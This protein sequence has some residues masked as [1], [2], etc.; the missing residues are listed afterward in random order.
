VIL[1]EQRIPVA[2]RSRCHDQSAT[3]DSSN[4]GQNMLYFQ[5][6][7]P[8]LGWRVDSECLVEAIWCIIPQA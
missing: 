7:I 6:A 4:I 5:H 8:F 3:G 1:A 2:N